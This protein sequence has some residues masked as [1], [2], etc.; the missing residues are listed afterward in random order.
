MS[1]P[2]EIQ[3]LRERVGSLSAELSRVQDVQSRMQR[4]RS[5]WE[6]RVK[7]AERRTQQDWLQ[8][9][10]AFYAAHEAERA[11]RYVTGLIYRVEQLPDR[12]KLDQICGLRSAAEIAKHALTLT[13]GEPAEHVFKQAHAEIGRLRTYIRA[14]GQRLHAESGRD[15]SGCDCTGCQLIIDMDIVAAVEIA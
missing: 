13:R 5:D 6:R 2:D 11:T 7:S 3:K 15:P 1:D 9:F 4:D 14:T 8:A 10:G 12:P